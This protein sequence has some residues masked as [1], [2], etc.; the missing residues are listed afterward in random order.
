MEGRRGT[1]PADA[2]G[3]PMRK[4]DSEEAIEWKARECAR[5]GSRR[6]TKGAMT[7]TRE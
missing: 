5:M 1:T 6:H 3:I 7:G 4:H 2:C